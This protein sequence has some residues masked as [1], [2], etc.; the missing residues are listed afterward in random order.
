[1]PRFARADGVQLVVNPAYLHRFKKDLDSYDKKLGLALRKR[2]RNAGN[3]GREE[4]I[5]ALR[6][7]SPGGGPNTGEGRAALI[8]ATKVSVSFSART[9]GAR[10]VTSASR[11]P[12]EH[13][14]LLNVYN[15]TTSRHP[16][17]GQPDVWVT[18]RGRPYFG[19]V[20]RKAGNRKILKEIEAAL[21]DAAKAIGGR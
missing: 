14:G 17:F 5:K 21:N 16:V 7:P 6:L 9:A 20:I 10:L 11:L 13:K 12:A 1:M 18:Q 4:V 3:I 2:I 15:S 19:T 8:A